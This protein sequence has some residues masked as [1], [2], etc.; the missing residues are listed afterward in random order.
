MTE[1][2][3][4]SRPRPGGR[5]GTSVATAAGA[6]AL[7]AVLAAGCGQTP[8]TG[9]QPS[10]EASASPP[11][12]ASSDAVDTAGEGDTETLPRSAPTGLQ[13][14]AIGVDT[15]QTV[16]LGTQENGQIEVPEGDSTVG[17][18]EG[19]PTPGEFGP[20]LM[21][22]HVDSESGPALFYRLADLT[23]GEEVRVVREDGVTAVFTVYSVEQYPKDAFPTR[24]VYA[25]TEHRAELRL[26]TCGGT[27][28]EET[29]HYR[30]NIVA[31]ASMTGVA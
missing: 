7:L 5:R 10:P 20:A 18:Y 9:G 13:I 11:S 31:Y 26:V 24:K 25:P 15:S 14:P 4:Q 1:S 2:A 17:W 16:A 21:G 28:D 8:A 6:I 27:F 12:A 19:G 22:A 23:G 3:Y 29:G 30:D